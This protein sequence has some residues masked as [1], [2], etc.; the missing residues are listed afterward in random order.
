MCFAR[1]SC[2]LPGDKF[3]H[4]EFRNPKVTFIV[5]C[6]PDYKKSINIVKKGNFIGAEVLKS[7]DSMGI[8]GHEEKYL[9]EKGLAV[10]YR[11]MKWEKGETKL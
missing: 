10:Q 9:S 8:L 5:L 2:R 3:L 7:A 11:V 6:F 1:G 4:T